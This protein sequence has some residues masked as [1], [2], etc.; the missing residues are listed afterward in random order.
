MSSKHKVEQRN[1]FFTGSSKTNIQ[2]LAVLIVT[3]VMHSSLTRNRRKAKCTII[4]FQINVACIGLCSVSL[5]PWFIAE[6][7][8]IMNQN[9]HR[10]TSSDSIYLYTCCFVI[11]PNMCRVR[12]CLCYWA[13]SL[14]VFYAKIISCSTL[15]TSFLYT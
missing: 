11:E 10:L 13:S 4:R 5:A 3:E 8:S 14:Q 12:W 1:Q 7:F 2:Y 6:D 9:Y 15:T